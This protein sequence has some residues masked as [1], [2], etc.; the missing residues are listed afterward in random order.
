MVTPD[1]LRNALVDADPA[2]Q[3]FRIV[4][5]GPS[6]ISIVLEAG[7]PVQA[8]VRIH[9]AMTQALARRGLFQK[10]P[11]RVVRFEAGATDRHAHGAGP[12]MT[13]SEG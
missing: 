2:I 8:D 4:Q 9:G 1:V 10:F 12:A 6:A 11:E 5:T 13:G 7:L 3:D